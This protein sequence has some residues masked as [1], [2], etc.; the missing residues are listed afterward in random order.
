MERNRKNIIILLGQK[1]N[2]NKAGRTPIKT[3][4]Y[5]KVYT[6]LERESKNLITNLWGKNYHKHPEKL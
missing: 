5:Y 6:N 3:L 1:P 4:K 2:K